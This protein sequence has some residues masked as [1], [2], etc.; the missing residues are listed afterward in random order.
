MWN[1]RVV[2]KKN[3]KADAINQK[4][5]VRYTYAIHEAYYDK[6]GHVGAITQAPIEPFGEDIE[7]LR[8]AWV[9]MAEAFRLPILDFD[10]IPEA[11]YERKEDP[12]ASVVD[13]RIK[14]LEAG[15]IKGIPWEHVRRGLE[16][17]YG[18]FDEE[19]DEKQA[20]AERV[21]R[22]GYTLKPLSARL[23]WRTSSTR[24]TPAIGHT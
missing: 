4:E 15:D 14:E 16:E 9:M 18:T 10:T 12:I 11:G 24:S 1:Y 17:R 19:E 3:A 5:R 20:E 23:H 21:G 22:R 2:R 8:H 6:N 7:E 13:E